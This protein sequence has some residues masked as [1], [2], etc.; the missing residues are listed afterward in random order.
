MNTAK[1]Y[2]QDQ[3]NKVIT[4]GEYQ[5]TFKIFGANGEGDTKH[6]NLNADSAQVL[7][8]WLQMIVDRHKPRTIEFTRVN[9]DSFGNP[10]YVC[11]FTAIADK[12]S[13]ALK[14]CKPFGGRKFDNKQFGGGIVFQSYNIDADAKKML[15]AL[16]E[17]Q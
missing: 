14:F 8:D 17:L 13:D 2:Y 5:P 10:R 11:H 4:T 7:I 9:S 6:M 12:Y 15:E 3:I 1:K 16:K